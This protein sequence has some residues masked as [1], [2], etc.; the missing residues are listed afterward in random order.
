MAWIISK[1]L[2]GFSILSQATRNIFNYELTI[3]KSTNTAIHFIIEYIINKYIKKYNRLEVYNSIINNIMSMND[4]LYLMNK[5]ITIYHQLMLY[6]TL[7]YLNQEIIDSYNILTENRIL[8]IIAIKKEHFTK[9][10]YAIQDNIW[11]EEFDDFIELLVNYVLL[12]Q[13]ETGYVYY[14][15]LYIVVSEAYKKYFTHLYNISDFSSWYNKKEEFQ[16]ISQTNIQTATIVS[17]ATFK[18]RRVPFKLNKR[19]DQTS[20][21]RHPSSGT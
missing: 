8:M 9:N 18:K 1:R 12:Y 21:Y 2:F 7:I 15:S 20:K 11:I 16:T 14:N 5:C 6:I 10:I 19:H 17:P 4:I 13:V 3:E